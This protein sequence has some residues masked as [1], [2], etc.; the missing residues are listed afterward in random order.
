MTAGILFAG[1][2]GKEKPGE[3]FS[4]SNSNSDYSSEWESDTN[5][6][7]LTETVVHFNSDGGSVVA[8]MLLLYGKAVGQLP[9]PTKTEY[10]L[11]VGNM[12][13]AAG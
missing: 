4:N 10:N 5:S 3:D 7:E 2:S 13:T 6:T 1:C 8:D 9:V 11:S 12:T